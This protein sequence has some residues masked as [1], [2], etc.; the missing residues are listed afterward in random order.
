MKSLRPS[1]VVIKDSLVVQSSNDGMQVLGHF[2]LSQVGA[3]RTA[4]F[5][6][7]IKE[8]MDDSLTSGP[9][10]LEKKGDVVRIEHLE[11]ED[12]VPFETSRKNMID[13]IHHWQGWCSSNAS[14]ACSL[15]GY[16]VSIERSLDRSSFD[17]RSHKA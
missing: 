7:W 8:L 16:S 5:I 6:K 13:I 10:F 11:L 12:V 15:G 3:D 4:F 1:S 14:S 17:F 9:Y 2:L